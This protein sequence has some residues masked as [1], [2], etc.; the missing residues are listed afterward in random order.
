[1]GIASGRALPVLFKDEMVR[2]EFLRE[3][4][5]T[6]MTLGDED[7][8]VTATTNGKTN[9]DGSGSRQDSAW[10]GDVHEFGDA[11]KNSRSNTMARQGS[12]S[13]YRE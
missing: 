10:E 5:A 3:R 4:R 1:M 12:M 6:M 7:V 9:G 13:M 2:E 8:L 11:T